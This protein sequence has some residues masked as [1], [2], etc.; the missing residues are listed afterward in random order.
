MAKPALHAEGR[1]P[2]RVT[3]NSCAMPASPAQTPQTLTHVFCYTDPRR[4]LYCPV[5]STVPKRSS[6]FSRGMRTPEKRREPLSTPCKPTCKRSSPS[7]HELSL[8]QV[9]CS[10]DGARSAT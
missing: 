8:V 10:P 4:H 7:S 9:W 6:R 5:L 1:P 2:S 3:L